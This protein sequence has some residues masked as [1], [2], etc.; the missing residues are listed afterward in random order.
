MKKKYGIKKIKH[1]DYRVGTIVKT[2]KK[3]LVE[4]KKKELIKIKRNE[5]M[6]ISQ[7]KYFYLN[8]GR[9]LKNL[10]EFSFALKDMP[11]K[12]YN[13]H[14]R[15]NNNDFASWVKDVFN[16]K[17]LAEELK[18]SKTMAIAFQKIKKYL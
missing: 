6:K 10:K 2:Q 5:L 13:Y 9:I 18:K 3:E 4:V 11:N 15:K 12:I 17:K 14:V 7:D 8:D 16:N 1:S